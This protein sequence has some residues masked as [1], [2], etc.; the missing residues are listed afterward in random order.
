MRISFDNQFL[1]TA[2]TDG[3]LMI[4]EIRDRDPRG[5]TMKQARDLSNMLQFSEEILT[6]KQEMEEYYTQRETLEN[7]LATIKDSNHQSVGEKVGTN[8]QEEKITKL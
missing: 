1:F 2:S 4:M 7:D 8:D 5:G 6:E 3:S